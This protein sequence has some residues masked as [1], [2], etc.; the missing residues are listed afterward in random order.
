MFIFSKLYK[1]EN[2]TERRRGRGRGRRRRRRKEEEE[3]EEKAVYTLGNN[4]RERANFLDGE[5]R[6]PA[7]RSCDEST[8]LLGIFPKRP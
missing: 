3:G 6:V 8:D 5:T 2:P 1:E 4:H 7:S